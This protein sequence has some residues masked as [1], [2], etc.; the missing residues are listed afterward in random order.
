MLVSYPSFSLCVLGYMTPMRLH[1]CGYMHVGTRGRPCS[2]PSGTAHYLCEDRVSPRPETH[3]AGYSDF[4][5]KLRDL[6]PSLSN[7]KFQNSKCIH[8]TLFSPQGSGNRTQVCV[9]KPRTLPTELSPPFVSSI[10]FTNA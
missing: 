1:V 3:R 2:L 9:C 6:T 4:L 8:R 10:T 7:S 5:V